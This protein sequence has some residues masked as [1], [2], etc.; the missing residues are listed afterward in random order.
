MRGIGPEFNRQYKDIPK[1]KICSRGVFGG[2]YN[3]T[4]T[5]ILKLSFVSPITSD[6]FSFI[7]VCQDNSRMNFLE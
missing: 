2:F 1:N 3:D 5:R 7:L 6:M 4:N